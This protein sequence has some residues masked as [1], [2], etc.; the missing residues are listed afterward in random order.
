MVWLPWQQRRV[1]PAPATP[2]DPETAAGLPLAIRSPTA[3]PDITLAPI[4]AT[5][6]DGHPTTPICSPCQRCGA[7]CAFYLVSFP[8]DEATSST[9]NNELLDLSLPHGETSRFM[10]GTK[11]RHPRCLALLG[12]VGGHVT[13]RI[14]QHRPSTCRAFQRS[15]E[16]DAGNTLCDRARGV[17]GLEPFS[18][19]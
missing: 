9:G 5:A 17:F 3:L 11:A 6:S 1:P 18:Q 10:K 7:C 4:T 2:A 8:G 19:Y 14:Y 16:N 15:W 12:T 13:C